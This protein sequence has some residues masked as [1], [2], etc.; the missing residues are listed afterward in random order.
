MLSTPLISCSIGEA[1]VSARTSAE[2]PGYVAVTW[3]VG[4]TISG[5][6]VIGSARY[7]IAP[8]RLRM[9]EITPAKIGRSM[10]KWENEPI[11]RRLVEIF[12]VLQDSL[13]ACLKAAVRVGEL[14]KD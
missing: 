14:P 5:Y 10:K 2:A 3:T 8:I 12:N 1:M 13:T 4:G 11:R 6:S 9:T 7:E